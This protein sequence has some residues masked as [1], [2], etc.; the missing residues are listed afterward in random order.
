M[1]GRNTVA[2]RRSGAT[3]EELVRWTGGERREELRE[4]LIFS[5]LCSKDKGKE[6]QKRLLE[7]GSAKEAQIWSGNPT[8]CWLDRFAARE[9]W[10]R[11][12]FARTFRVRVEWQQRKSARG[13]TRFVDGS[14]RKHRGVRWEPA[15]GE[16]AY[17]LRVSR[18]GSKG[19]RESAENNCRGE[20]LQDDAEESEGILLSYSLAKEQVVTWMRVIT[21]W[22]HSC[23]G[24]QFWQIHRI[25]HWVCWRRQLQR[26]TM[27]DWCQRWRSNDEGSEREGTQ[28][29]LQASLRRRRNAMMSMKSRSTMRR[30]GRTNSVALILPGFGKRMREQFRGGNPNCV[31]IRTRR[32]ANSATFHRSR[33]PTV[34]WWRHERSEL[35]HKS[36][37]TE[38][39]QLASRSE[40]ASE[41]FP[42]WKKKHKNVSDEGRDFFFFEG[43]GG[44]KFRTTFNCESERQKLEKQITMSERG[45]AIAR[46]REERSESDCFRSRGST[47]HLYNR[48][49]P[50]ENVSTICG[51]RNKEIPPQ[52]RHLRYCSKK[53]RANRDWWQ[54]QSLR[55]GTS[56]RDV[57]RSAMNTDRQKTPQTFDEAFYVV[58][59]LFAPVVL[60]QSTG[61]SLKLISDHQ[62][63]S[64]V[65]MTRKKGVTNFG[66]PRIA[67]SWYLWHEI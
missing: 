60:S 8:E 45:T 53:F 42:K 20:S 56:R 64:L 9:R 43:E 49:N 51:E 16:D 32:R 30:A 18:V 1:C 47:S 27:A 58:D 29:Q 12:S 33:V 48:H 62:G 67:V 50:P 24:G 26:Q 23:P 5:W 11:S 3:N 37:V 38:L 31:A 39:A 59:V 10:G 40:H 25:F 4:D 66:I 17:F 13:A 36:C 46:P 19:S 22:D 63:T 41:L 61:K 54:T 21:L 14:N 65:S 34:M 28:D 2:W 7:T 57:A 6:A 44:W 35:W 15:A 55:R 52:N